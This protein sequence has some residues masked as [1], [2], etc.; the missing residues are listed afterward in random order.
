MTTTVS[1]GRLLNA[2]RSVVPGA[3][4]NQIQAVM[5]DIL[6][7]FFQFT[8]VWQET[9][10]VQAVVNQ[11]HYDLIPTGVCDIIRL[12]VVWVHDDPQGNAAPDSS[13]QDNRLFKRPIAADMAIPG[14]LRILMPISSLPFPEFTFHAVVSK[15]CADPTDSN[16]NPEM[17]RWIL[18]KYRRDFVDGI[19]GQ[20]MAQPAKTYS[21]Q[22]M[23]VY[24]K[25]RW[26]NAMTG[27]RIEV[28]RFNTYGAQAWRFPQQYRTIP[29]H[30]GGGYF[31]NWPV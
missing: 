8:N 15:K 6:D 14:E 2:V 18:T 24:H 22:T 30:G 23:A 27:A 16:G 31:G 26:R 12:M 21:N 28:N 10:P 4:D 1:T 7:E 11:Q 29:R 13:T 5:F 9:I 20:L 25:R 17:P 3:L 19:A